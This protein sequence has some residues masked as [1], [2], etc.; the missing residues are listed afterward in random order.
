MVKKIIRNK[1]ILLL[2]NVLLNIKASLTRIM[3]EILC[4][5]FLV[6][7]PRHIFSSTQIYRPKTVGIYVVSWVDDYVK[8]VT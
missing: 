8:Q 3:I 2:Q 4:I 5:V 7:A 6:A 1:H